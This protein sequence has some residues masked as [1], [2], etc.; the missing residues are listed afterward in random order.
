MLKN[1]KNGYQ[2]SGSSAIAKEERM[3][4]WLEPLQMP[5]T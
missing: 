4:A 1:F 5:V 3:I 2:V